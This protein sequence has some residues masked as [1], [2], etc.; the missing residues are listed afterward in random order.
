MTCSPSIG[1]VHFEYLVEYDCSVAPDGRLLDSAQLG[2]TRQAWLGNTWHP[3]IDSW[4]GGMCNDGIECPPALTRLPCS[5][6]ARSILCPPVWPRKAQ[7]SFVRDIGIRTKTHRR[8]T[9]RERSPSDQIG[10]NLL[11]RLNCHRKKSLFVTKSEQVT[12]R[13]HFDRSHL[14]V[15]PVVWTGETWKRKKRVSLQSPDFDYLQSSRVA[16]FGEEKIAASLA[17]LMHLVGWTATFEW[18]RVS[19]RL[20]PYITRV[21]AECLR[22]YLIGC[23][24]YNGIPLKLRHLH[25]HQNHLLQLQ[26]RKSKNAVALLHLLLHHWLS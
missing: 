5:F 11:L 14:L 19:S 15:Q 17:A 13:K 21:K 25:L 2:T 9:C 1:W 22:S 6:L 8:K 16:S 3:G 7:C 26:G 20:L 12:N 10:A 23:L 4:V 18:R 24:A